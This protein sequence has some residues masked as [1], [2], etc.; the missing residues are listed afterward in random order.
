M[1]CLCLLP[2]VL[3]ALAPCRGVDEVNIAVILP[4][5]NSRLFSLMKTIPAL[6]YAIDS[7][8]SR[9]LLP[10]RSLDVVQ[11]DSRCDAIAAP[12]AAFDY[13][14]R[15]QAHVF[16]GPVCDYSLAPVARYAPYWRIPVVTPGGMAH[17]FGKDKTASGAE[18]PTLTRIGCTFNSLAEYVFNSVRRFGWRRL[19]V[20]YD[21]DGHSD[22]VHR[23]CY[24]A[25]SA[26]VRHVVERENKKEEADSSVSQHVFLFRDAAADYGQILTDEIG[27]KFSS[28]TSFLSP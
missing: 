11:A 12:I 26:V 27:T 21:P 1:S 18:F 6:Q 23:F 22:I 5:N 13:H 9:G 4:A 15:R 28:K 10:G 20:M 3:A 19:K 24:L 16:F 14:R 7:V 17:D 2:L 8:R 25:M